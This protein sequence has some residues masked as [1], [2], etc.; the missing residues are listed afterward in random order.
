MADREFILTHKLATTIR[1]FDAP[2]RIQ[3]PVEWPE[4]H[5]LS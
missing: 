4:N 1:K 5:Q 2:A 3:T